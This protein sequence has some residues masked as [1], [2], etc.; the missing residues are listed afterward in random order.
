MRLELAFVCHFINE[1]TA[2]TLMESIQIYMFYYLF[3]ILLI[4][5]LAAPGRCCTTGVKILVTCN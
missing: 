5:M 4:H 3:V 1:E 2:L